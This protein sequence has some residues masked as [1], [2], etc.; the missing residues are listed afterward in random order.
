MVIQCPGVFFYSVLPLVYCAMSFL[1]NSL[2][3]PNLIFLSR[4]F[5]S[6]VIVLGD[7]AVLAESIVPPKLIVPF[8]LM[9]CSCAI[10]KDAYLSFL[11]FF[12][13]NSKALQSQ[14]IAMQRLM[15]VVR[16]STERD[17]LLFSPWTVEKP[18]RRGLAL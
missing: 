4:S 14:V 11:V 8:C 3:P 9:N 7:L 18:G 2:F 17:H 10:S 6:N 13:S 16:V 15:F 5:F 12:L 1:C